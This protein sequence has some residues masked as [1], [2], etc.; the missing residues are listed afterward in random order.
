MYSRRLK[1]VYF[2][3][4]GINSFAV[5][6]YFY[7]LFFHLRDQFGFGNTANLAVCALHGCIFMLSAWYGGRF[8]QRAGYLTSL[9][10]GFS[11]MGGT[12][13]AGSFLPS[14]VAQLG[15]L[16]V[17]TFGMC[18]TWPALEALA[19]E[20]ETP[21][22]LPRMIG[23]YNVTWAAGAALAYFVGGALFE[24]LGARSLFWFPALLHGVQIVIVLA[25]KR[26]A[27]RAAGHEVAPATT[28]AHAT[29]A[30]DLRLPPQAFLRMAWLA[31]PFAYVAMN[32]MIPVI[33]LLAKELHLSTEQA[34]FF[35]SVWLFARLA[36]FFLLWQWT[37]WHYR[38]RWLLGSFILLI[39]C[40]AVI[41][42][43]LN[44]AVIIAAQIGFGL[45]VGLIYYS[46]LFYSMDVGQ[47]KGEHGGIH[48][49]AIGCGVFGGAGLGAAGQWAFGGT[50][51]STWVVSGVL[52]L[53][54]AGLVW[55]RS[56]ATLR[57]ATDRKMAK[58]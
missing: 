39:V 55:I 13:V 36:A 57:A 22:N 14:L 23:I 24:K 52:V 2:L 50:A 1:S 38:F 51:S 56:R 46:S 15:V 32:A 18:F 33:P 9:T 53:G 49:S 6:Y 34:G 20:R 17:W 37:G 44:L 3:L 58:A 31:N 5:S 40:F 48:E 27:G 41:L 29:P 47:T 42:L 54:L 19:S 11:I 8:A 10:V 21:A 7:Y 28:A 26:L 35:C 25:A 30:T 43:T 12:L 4:E 16:A 45:A